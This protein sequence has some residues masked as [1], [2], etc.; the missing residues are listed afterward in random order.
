M[1]TISVIV[2]TTGRPTLAA[3]LD[4]IERQISPAD[5]VVVV[6]DTQEAP[7][8]PSSNVRCVWTGGRENPCTARNI[9]AKAATSEYISFLDDDDTWLETHLDCVRRGIE[10]SG[11]SVVCTSFW[12]LDATGMHAGLIAP[13]RLEFE[14]FL[15]RN[16][17][18]RGSNLT[19]AAA[20]FHRVGGFDSK[21]PAMN[22][23]DLGI[24]LADSDEKYL[25]IPTRTVI[26]RTHDGPRLS[27][28]GSAANRNGLLAFWQRY[29]KRMHPDERKAYSE[30][31]AR[32]W[33]FT[34]FEEVAAEGAGS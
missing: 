6:Y 4:S 17:G 28:P 29:A 2:T 25:G 20:A 11:A 7:P 24:R 33:G 22:D 34:D 16:P 30:W 23:L 31:A 18:L 5:E 14:R 9:G 10:S 3:A 12:D 13:E 32:F 21:F 19:I 27:T 15:C 1:T 8:P 26:F